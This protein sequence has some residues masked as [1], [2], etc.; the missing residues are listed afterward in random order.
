[1]SMRDWKLE[2]EKFEKDAL[3]LMILWPKPCAFSP[4]ALFRNRPA[5]VYEIIGLNL[6]KLM[7]RPILFNFDF[8]IY[9]NN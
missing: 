8:Y 1:M 2:L 4:E 9:F 7:F 5:F 6:S 3:N